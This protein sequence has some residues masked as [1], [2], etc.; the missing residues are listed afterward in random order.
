MNN[1]GHRMSKLEA[2]KGLDDTIVIIRT[3][4]EPIHDDQGR[5]IGERT[6][7]A[8]KWNPELGRYEDYSDEPE[9]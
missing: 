3:M 4:V 7:K 5:L 1:L 2:A 6:L 8:V 9:A